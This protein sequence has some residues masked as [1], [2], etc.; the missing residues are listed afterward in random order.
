MGDITTP[1]RGSARMGAFLLNPQL[2]VSPLFR[3]LCSAACLWDSARKKPGVAMFRYSGVFVARSQPSSKFQQ[4]HFETGTS[5]AVRKMTFRLEVEVRTVSKSDARKTD[6][7]S[8]RIP[9]VFDDSDGFIQHVLTHSTAEI[10]LEKRLGIVHPAK[11]ASFPCRISESA[12]FCRE[13][14]GRGTA[15]MVVFRKGGAARMGHC[16]RALSRFLRFNK[17]HS[18][19]EPG[20][21]HGRRPST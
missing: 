17:R 13:T 16:S 18:N 15:K 20:L 12:E 6:T 10:Q 19:R 2:W 9:G 7:A 14:A 5:R 11:Q 3:P 8:Y 4:R 1:A 21:L